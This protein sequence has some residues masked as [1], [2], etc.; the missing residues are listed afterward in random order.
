VIGSGVEMTD[1]AIREVSGVRVTDIMDVGLSRPPDDMGV[2]FSRPPDDLASSAVL[3]AM[4][5]RGAHLVCTELSTEALSP[6]SSI[7]QPT[8][9]R[10]QKGVTHG[11]RQVESTRHSPHQRR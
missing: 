1:G 9:A 8:F 7:H 10:L 3:S 11:S 4:R 6:L 2:G 5:H